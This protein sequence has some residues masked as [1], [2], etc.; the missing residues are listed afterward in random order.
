MRNE[1]CNWNSF[2]YCS[3][4][5]LSASYQGSNIN[6]VTTDVKKCTFSPPSLAYGYMGPFKDRNCTVVGADATS[7]SARD[8]NMPSSSPGPKSPNSAP[9]SMLPSFFM[10]VMSVAFGLAAPALLAFA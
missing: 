8:G 9:A 6:G 4:A 3:N 1:L 5:E 2:Y 7:P 10:S